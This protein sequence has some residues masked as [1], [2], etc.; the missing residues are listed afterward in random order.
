MD[1][2]DTIAGAEL[3]LFTLPRLVWS[4]ET[5][6]FENVDYAPCGGDCLAPAPGLS[7]LLSTSV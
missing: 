3:F 5:L 4:L 2:G 7:L 1:G 6:F